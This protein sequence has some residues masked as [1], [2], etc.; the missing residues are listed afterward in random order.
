VACHLFDT[1]F[2]RN[3]R[4]PLPQPRSTAARPVRKRGGRET[5]IEA[6]SLEVHFPITGGILRRTIGHVRAV[7]GVNLA[8]ARGS[9]VA[10]VGESGSGKTTLGK[11]MV[12]LIPRTGG[13]IQAGVALRSQI[14]FQDPYASLNPRL[15][16]GEIVAEGLRY[17]P[18]PPAR[19]ERERRV[20]ETLALVGLER[21]TASRYPHEFSGGQRQ[22]I[23]IARALVVNPEFLVC[24]EPTSALDVSVQAQILNLLR[25]LK[26]RLGLTYLFITH[27]LG[28]VEYFADE[29]A[30]MREG[31]I[32]EAGPVETVFRRPR[33]AYT[34]EL[35]KAVPKLAR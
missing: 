17:R 24:D 11:A 21:A 28:V 1:E 32:V 26:D 2:P 18:D 8:V 15:T 35:L 22:R 25:G 7:D 6:R 3:Q 10:V 9:V 27:D 30:V 16:V 14:I 12:G 34:R 23:G 29:V 33:Q 20:A 4:K 19:A 5:L 13:A 31:R